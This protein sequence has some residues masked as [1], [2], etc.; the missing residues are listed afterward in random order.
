MNGAREFYRLKKGVQDKM[1]KHHI[2]IYAIYMRLRGYLHSSNMLPVIG[3]Q[4][5]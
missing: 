4:E 1:V 2:V 5:T 3:W